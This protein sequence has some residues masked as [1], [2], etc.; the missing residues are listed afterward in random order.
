MTKTSNI[1]L[2]TER[3]GKRGTLLR[4]QLL[5]AAVSALIEVGVARTTTLDVQRRA[6]SSRGALLHHFPT[7]A[8]LLSATVAE[9][10]RR[11]DAAIEAA[12]P[13]MARYEKPVE[14][15]IRTLAQMSLQPAF[16]AEMELWAAARTDPDLKEAL[17]EAERLAKGE[18]ERVINEVFS[19]VG[20]SPHF[21]TLV[22][23]SRRFLS[24]LALTE[25]LGARVEQR[26]QLIQDWCWAAECLLAQPSCQTV[27]D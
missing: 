25:M 12:K 17:R 9:L 1:L 8:Q 14:R 27:T 11:N 24:G 15:A 22:R 19:E 20:P 2:G 3:R 7:H 18:R 13:E 6:G 10:V 4:Q 23:L 5:D 16:M 21:A 26:E